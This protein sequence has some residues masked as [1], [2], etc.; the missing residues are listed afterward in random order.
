MADD[1]EDFGDFTSAFN[2]TS[3]ATSTQSAASTA[4]EAKSTGGVDF[5]AS[6]PPTSG[7]QALNFASFDAFSNHATAGAMDGEGIP[8]FDQLDMANMNL[9]ELKIPSPS[10]TGVHM[11]GGVAFDI[12]PLTDGDFSDPSSP[13]E[14]TNEI[15]LHSDVFL[16]NF[17]KS[18]DDGRQNDIPPDV[19]LSTS[20]SQ[21]NGQPTLDGQEDKKDDSFGDFESSFSLGNDAKSNFE[22]TS[23]TFPENSMSTSS[24]KE[25]DTTFEQMQN[26]GNKSNPV[27]DLS[28][29]GDHCSSSQKMTNT[30][31]ME[32]SVFTNLGNS[33]DL[34][35]NVLGESTAASKRETDNG[36]Q[37]QAT[38]P[39]A[40]HSGNEFASFDQ[41]K[42][43]ESTSMA[44]E[45][46]QF[47]DFGAFSTSSATS[48]Q[49]NQES[50]QFGDFGAFSSTADSVREDDQLGDF[51][52]FGTTKTQVNEDDTQ[53]GDFG[54]FSNTNNAE[55]N[56]G[57]SPFGDFSSVSNTASTTTQN[58][59][60]GGFGSFQAQTTSASESLL[61]TAA[62]HQ[63][64][65]VDD[66][67]TFSD[68]MSKVD[69]FGN[70]A[71]SET[72]NFATSKSSDFSA[73]TDTKG[74]DDFGAFADDTSKDDDFGAFAGDTNEDNAFGDFSSTNDSTFGSFATSSEA[75]PQAQGRLSDTHVSKLNVSVND[76]C[77]HVVCVA[78]W[79]FESDGRSCIV[80]VCSSGVVH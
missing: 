7:D 9:A 37:S 70:F 62:A 4:N 42:T 71:T 17:S 36:E 44:Q 3:D 6:F 50:G 16:T 23:G 43:S 1:G 14:L 55:E 68:S 57:D 5:F 30:D 20:L 33:L 63:A 72:G 79:C 41:L 31:E 74:D 61:T 56:Q 22:S 64:P 25:K 39:L 27:K 78:A 35:D 76:G 46:H 8:N 75:L 69:D 28:E 59:E 19:H 10:H 45:D 13:S 2:D 67:G 54:A 65:P 24:I 26:L 15:K 80:I 66:F 32:S 11:A 38:G 48:A 40:H 21:Q 51:A 29:F 58:D 18:D 34:S 60:F 52:S 49:V 77:M 47:G 12:P 73:F 53:F